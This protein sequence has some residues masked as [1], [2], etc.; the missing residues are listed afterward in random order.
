MSWVI[1][2]SQ[3]VNWD[4]SL[5]T[6]ALWLDA[7]DASTITESGGAVSQW[8]DKSGNSNNFVQTILANRPTYSATGFNNK[9]AITFDGTNDSME[10]SSRLAT[11]GRWVSI[12][13][14]FSETGRVHVPFNSATSGASADDI[15][16]VRFLTIGTR[17]GFGGIGGAG[18]T[19]VNP[20][21]TNTGYIFN[22]GQVLNGPLRTN[23]ATVAT[24][25]PDKDAT[26][27][28]INTTQLGADGFSANRLKGAIQEVIIAA[29]VPDL[30]TVQKTEGYLAHKW[31]L[32]ANFPS[33]HPYKVNPPAP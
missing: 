7:A 32:T 30:L 3:K 26:A 5:I 33:D 8:N 1:T 27:F 15:D 16:N 21:V 24:G 20:Y 6:T 4:P 28:A 22:W 12:L 13:V 19:F 25:T 2:G 11:A 17:A 10:F 18:D 29:T 23:G 14:S 31:G 9:A